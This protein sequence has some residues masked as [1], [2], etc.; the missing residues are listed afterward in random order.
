MQRRKKARDGYFPIIEIMDCLP[1]QTKIISSGDRGNMQATVFSIIF[2]EIPAYWL[3]WGNGYGH[4][5]SFDT[6][7]L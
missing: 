7:P 6:K 2:P 4:P 3:S 5:L 1:E